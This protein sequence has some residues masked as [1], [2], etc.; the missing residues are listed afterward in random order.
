[1][2]WAYV[3]IKKTSEYPLGLNPQLTL[4]EIDISLQ[5]LGIVNKTWGSV[6]NNDVTHCLSN[7]VLLWIWLLFIHD[8]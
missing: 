2:T 3:C 6:D 7:I 1:M 8:Q 5:K 4:S